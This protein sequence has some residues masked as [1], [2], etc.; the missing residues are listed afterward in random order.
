MPK[1]YANA[2]GYTNIYFG[3]RW[4]WKSQQAVIDAYHAY[5]DGHII[6]S[7]LWLNFPHIRFTKTKE[8][9]MILHE[10]ADYNHNVTMPTEAPIQMLKEYKMERKRTRKILKYFILID[11][12]WK[13]FNSRNWHKNFHDDILVDMLTEPRKYNLTVIGVTQAW[14]RIDVQF[15]ELTQDW[16]LFS[17]SGWWIFEHMDCVHIWVHDWEFHYENP[18]IID[19]NRKWVYWNKMLLFYRTLYYTKEIV[20]TGLYGGA[21]PHLFSPWDIFSPKEGEA[22]KDAEADEAPTG[23]EAKAEI[24]GVGGNPP[25]WQDTNSQ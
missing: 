11:E 24:M 17:K 16:F 9:P 23:V 4:S 2:L 8:L 3:Q 19:R 12:I 18:I 21:I 20:G 22:N 5:M 7:N 15:R 10:I 25:D 1:S 14:K 13:H 6:I